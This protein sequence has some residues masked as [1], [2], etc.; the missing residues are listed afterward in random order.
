MD[1]WSMSRLAF[2]AVTFLASAAA[3]SGLATF[4][5]ATGN[6]DLAP[7][8]L[9]AAMAAASGVGA[10]GMAFLALLRGWGKK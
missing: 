3:L 2:Y 9:Y 7:F 1:K 8:N 4:D 5:Q 6:F 10:S